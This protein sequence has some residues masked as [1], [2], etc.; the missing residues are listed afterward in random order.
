MTRTILAP[1]RVLTCALALAFAAHLPARADFNA[2][3]PEAS[4]Q[5]P[6]FA[7]QTRAPE[8]PA[9]PRLSRT[10][11]ADGLQYPGAWPCCPMAPC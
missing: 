2:L 3:P 8:I 11:L 6:A 9:R 7:N 10:V 5:T 1:L 4:G